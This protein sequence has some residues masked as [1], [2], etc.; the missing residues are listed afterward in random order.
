[1]KCPYCGNN[2]S[3]VVDSRP[4]VDVIRR[5]RLCLNCGK[6]WTTHETTV[7]AVDGDLRPET[8]TVVL[9]AGKDNSYEY[10]LVKRARDRYDVE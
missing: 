2:K 5:R 4:Q 1:M 6:R 10:V 8:D 7:R 9:A 3:E